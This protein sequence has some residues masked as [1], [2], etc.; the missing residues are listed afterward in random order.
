MDGITDSMDMSVSRLREAVKDREA[1]RAAVHGV[2]ESQT[3]L[4]YYTTKVAR[5]DIEIITL[6]E[7]S[8]TG[9]DKYDATAMW[10][11]KKND[12]NELIYKPEIDSQTDLGV[13]NGESRDQGRT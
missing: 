12:T 13:T 2:T 3:R 11:L 8:Q 9:K 7:V 5:M 4:S 1:W 6:S 10:N